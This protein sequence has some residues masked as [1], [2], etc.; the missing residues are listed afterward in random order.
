V[1]TGIL[2]DYATTAAM[3]TFTA[4]KGERHPADMAMLRGARVVT[5]SETEEGKPW[6]ESRIKQM[7]GGDPVSA[8]FMR[9]DFFTFRPAFK[10]TIVGNHKPVLRNVD[11][12]MRRRF[13]IIPF[14]HKPAAPD[15]E[16]EQK[17]RAEWPGILRWM[18]DGCLDWQANGLTSPQSVN[19]ATESYFSEQ[20][21]FG[22]WL[23]EECAADAPGVVSSKATATSLL[24]A[25]W[26]VY[27]Q[28]AGE[29]PGSVKTF[30]E[31]MRR[32]GF[33]QYRS[34]RSRGFKGVALK[35]RGDQ[36]E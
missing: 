24:F 27:A 23:E 3:E 4:A 30:V 31:A 16:L 11:D 22:H 5:A 20:D 10:L 1:V 32:K 12:A 33:E 8:R 29:D 36:G 14:L 25:T 19:E 26:R 17:L 9:Q 13:R 2:Q 18:I 28:N 21:T 34:K 7:T 6:A 35:P 15:R